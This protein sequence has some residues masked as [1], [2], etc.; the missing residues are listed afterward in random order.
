MEEIIKIAAK[1]KSFGIRGNAKYQFALKNK[2]CGD[3]IKIEFDLINEKIF[4]FRYEGET[5][6]YCQAS[7]ALLAK[8]LNKLT[9]QKLF[10]LKKQIYDYFDNK[11]K[12]EN[13]ELF[14]FKQLLKKNHNTRKECI[15]LPLNAILN[16]L[17]KN[18][19]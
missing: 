2:N 16:S 5:C 8:N 7:A 9:L 10:R 6:I 3:H 18:D 4:N 19:N 1:T 17:E 12:K 14:D 11:F 15:A 13:L